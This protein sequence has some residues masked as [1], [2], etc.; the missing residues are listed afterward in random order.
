M[1][2]CGVVNSSAQTT[3]E[4]PVETVAAAPEKG[5]NYPYLLRVPEGAGPQPQVL[6]VEP[7]NTGAISDDFA[8]H[9]S[10]AERLARNSVGQFVARRLSIPLL[11]PVFPR[12]QTEWQIY[13]HLLDR[14]TIL[15]ES[16][17]LKRLDL[18]LMAMIDDA[19]ARLKARGVVVHQKV[20]MYG[21]SA[22]GAFVNRF[23]MLH[24]DRV[25]AVAAGGVN[26]MLM[27]PVEQL[28]SVAL[29]YPLGIADFRTVSGVAPQLEVWRRVA[30]FIYIGADDDNDAVLFSDGYTDDERAT[31]F[32]VIGEK[33]QPDRWERCQAVYRE[34]GANVTFRTYPGVGH[35]TNPLMVAA[36][37]DFFRTHAD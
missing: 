34:A 3:P 21:F 13:T 9:V 17:P 32:R 22:S 19:I 2:L 26:G 28:D 10:A 14:D 37:V 8:V 31:V 36:I 25:L 6:I 4:I 7:N 5:F 20:L 29:P 30:Q 18:Q 33:M 1:L 23:A 12:P 11:V 16:G 27:L 15:V 24:P 35:V